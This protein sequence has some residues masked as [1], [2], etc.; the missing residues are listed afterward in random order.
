M[1]RNIRTSR[2]NTYQSRKKKIGFIIVTG[3]IKL[4]IL[5]FIPQSEGF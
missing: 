4:T 1:L 2:S 5:D 3:N